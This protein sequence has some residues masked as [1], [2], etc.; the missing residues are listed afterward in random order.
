MRNEREVPG[1]AISA[2]GMLGT[3]AIGKT[4]SGKKKRKRT[5]RTENE[6]NPKR[7]D[8]WLVLFEGGVIGDW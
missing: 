1:W 4:D 5:K 6:T 8:G 2:I 3:S 7:K